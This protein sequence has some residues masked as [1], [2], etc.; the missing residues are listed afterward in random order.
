VCQAGY[1]KK[2]LYCS[3]S[4]MTTASCNANCCEKDT[5]KC[6]G[7]TAVTCATTNHY[8]D[9]MKAGTTFTAGSQSTQCCTAM[10]ACS[11]TPA[12]ACNVAR[13]KKMTYCSKAATDSTSCNTPCCELDTSTCRGVGT[14]SCAASHFQDTAKY[15]T[16]AT[17]SNKNTVCCT[18]RAPCPAPATP[19]APSP[20]PAPPPPPPG[21][22]TPAPTPPPPGSPP[23]PPPTTTTTTTVAGNVT[24]TM[25]VSTSAADVH[26]RPASLAIMAACLLAAIMMT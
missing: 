21:S 14:V 15:G 4:A 17:A 7:I 9:S 11:A 23:A 25:P 26:S 13:K 20:T 12:T 5:T 22:P 1:K 2:E 10:A 3:T 24:V 19:P 8:W 16:A 18:A 6:G